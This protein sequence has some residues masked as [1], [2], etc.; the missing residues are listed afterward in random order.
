[1]KL[2]PYMYLN[3][4]VSEQEKK[5]I[6]GKYSILFLSPESLFG[7]KWRAVISTDVYRDRVKVL[8]VDEAHCV[9]EWYVTLTV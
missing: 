2:S 4:F 6:G 9:V 1:M 3:Y 5:I 8:A 7:G